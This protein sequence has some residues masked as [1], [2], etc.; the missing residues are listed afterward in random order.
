MKKMIHE[1]RVFYKR[2]GILSTSFTCGYQTQCR[3]NHKNFTGPKSS[4]VSTGYEIGLLPRLLFLSL[5]SGESDVNNTARLPLRIRNK[6]QAVDVCQIRHNT[7][8]Y[9]TH[10]LAWY[11]L[12][13]FNPG[14]RIQ[15]T[16]MCFAHV[17]SAK[18]CMNKIG[19]KKANRVLFENCRHYL[20]KELFILCPEII[21][22]QGDEA[23]FAIEKIYDDCIKRI[24][25]D[26][27]A[28]IIG[29]RSDKVFWL[30]TYHPSNYGLFYSQRDFDADR[31]LAVGWDNYSKMIHRFISRKN[32][33]CLLHHTVHC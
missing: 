13:R 5:D 21:V 22:T 2:K 11:I 26:E 30:H 19:K 15:D 12:R 10:E 17:N 32:R 33:K 23:K 18:C 25:K 24:D 1:L 16:K 27:Y 31:N 28:S 9:R 3:G 29:L 20:E 8:W 6:L 7:H 4:F 14:L